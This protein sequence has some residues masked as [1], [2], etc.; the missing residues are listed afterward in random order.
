[1]SINFK[2][3]SRKK[4][5]SSAAARTKVTRKPRGKEALTARKPA[6]G[7][8]IKLTG[9]RTSL[10]QIGGITEDIE[11]DYDQVEYDLGYSRAVAALQGYHFTDAFVEGFIDG[12]GTKFD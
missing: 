11:I 6:S 8:T 10:A 5:S 7:W 1:M 9:L 2:W 12:L 4:A 3:P